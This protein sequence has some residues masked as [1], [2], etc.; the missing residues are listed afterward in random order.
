MAASESCK[1][2]IFL[3]NLTKELFNDD[4]TDPTDLHMDNQAA[5]DVSYN[6]E[7]HSR[8]KHIDRRHFFIRELV[9][10]KVIHTVFVG[11]CDN[12]ADF[13]T[14]PLPGKKF[15]AMRAAIMNERAGDATSR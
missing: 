10:D 8:M 1:E 11:T 5:I 13:F 9:E 12:L 7:H 2:A 6:P 14:K 4:D 3:R 15:F